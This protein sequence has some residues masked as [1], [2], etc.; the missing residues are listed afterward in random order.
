MPSVIKLGIGAAGPGLAANET[1]AVLVIVLVLEGKVS[2][3]SAK[4]AILR[5]LP[6]PSSLGVHLI[7]GRVL[8]Y[9]ARHGRG[10]H[11]AGRADCR[12]FHMIDP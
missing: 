12:N 2:A 11:R 1:L 9:N 8:D 7:D 4:G 10:W 6:T 3:T 5:H